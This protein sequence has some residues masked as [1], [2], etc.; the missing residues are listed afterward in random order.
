M[1]MGSATSQHAAATC[2]ECIRVGKRYV[3]PLSAE[4]VHAHALPGLATG[5]QL[6]CLY[7]PLVLC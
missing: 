4:V 6:C 5:G 3:R 1:S 2:D 7:Y